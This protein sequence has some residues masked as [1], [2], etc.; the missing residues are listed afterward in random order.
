[1]SKLLARIRVVLT[2]APTYLVAASTVVTVLREEIVAAFPGTAEEIGAVAVP[3]LATLSAAVAI[4][5]RV[6][7]V[8]PEERGILKPDAD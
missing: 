4:I 1:M 2:A 7:P 8:I 3:V 6:T 5:R